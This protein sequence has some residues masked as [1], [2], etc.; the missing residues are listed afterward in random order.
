MRALH[1]TNRAFLRA[2]L[3]RVDQSLGYPKPGLFVDGSPAPA[4]QGVTLRH[5]RLVCNAS[6]GEWAYPVVDAAQRT[7]LTAIRNAIKARVDAGTATD[8][9][10]QVNAALPTTVADAVLDATWDDALDD[11]DP[12]N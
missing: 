11:P 7:R 6:T 9:E 2:L 4:G 1:H 12:E 5:V 3:A 10:S 8:L